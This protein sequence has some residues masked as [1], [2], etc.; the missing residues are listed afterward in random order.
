MVQVIALQEF[1]VLPF[2]G[3][4]EWVV[5]RGKHCYSPIEGD[6]VVVGLTIITQ[7]RPDKLVGEF[8][9]GPDGAIVVHRFDQ[10]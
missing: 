5:E 9:W 3:W 4:G 2:D 10:S 8:W 6:N 7:E 1:T